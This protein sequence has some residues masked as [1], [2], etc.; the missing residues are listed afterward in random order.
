MP[1]H[2]TSDAHKWINEIPTVPI[3]YLPKP[4]PR[5]RA[6]DNQLRKKT[7]Y[8]LGSVRY[9]GALALVNYHYSQFQ[10]TYSVRL[11]PAS[12]HVFDY[13]FVPMDD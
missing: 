12:Q 3:Y 13:K 9:V 1:C 11:K 2:P 8:D 6:W 7:L 5:E 4:K 10:F